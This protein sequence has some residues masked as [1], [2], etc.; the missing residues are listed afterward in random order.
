[1][2]L[3][4]FSINIFQIFTVIIAASSAWFTLKNAKRTVR[5]QKNQT[6]VDLLSKLI[7]VVEPSKLGWENLIAQKYVSDEH[8]MIE[9]KTNTVVKSKEKRGEVFDRGNSFAK[10]KLQKQRGS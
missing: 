3:I 8:L 1:M 4:D 9:K 5:F 10:N 6:I 7:S 2:D